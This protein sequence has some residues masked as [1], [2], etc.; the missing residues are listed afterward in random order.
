MLRHSP[1]RHTFRL[2]MMP[3]LIHLVQ[4]S[5]QHDRVILTRQRAQQLPTGA[6]QRRVH[7]S[8]RFNFRLEVLERRKT[9][10]SRKSG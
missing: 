9:N 2:Q 4:S 1:Y 8:V 6:V 3:S 10:S 7:V 5:L